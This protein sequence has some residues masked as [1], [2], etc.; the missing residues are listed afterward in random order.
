MA[1]GRLDPRDREGAINLAALRENIASIDELSRDWAFYR[2]DPL[3]NS[4]PELIERV[5]TS[6]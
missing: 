1:R 5:R 4:S 6:L 2:A 3:V